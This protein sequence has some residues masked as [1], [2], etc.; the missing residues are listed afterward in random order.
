MLVAEAIQNRRSIRSYQTREVPEDT[1][2][3]IL[4]LTRYTP[5][6][7][8]GQPWRFVVIRDREIKN[9]L[10]EIKR[11]RCPEEKK[12]YAASYLKNAPVVVAICVER[13]RS[14]DRPIENGVLA[15]GYLMLAATARGL[16][17]VYLSAY[18]DEDPELAREVTSLLELP[19]DTFPV[20]LIPLGFAAE[21]PSPKNLRPLSEMV[22]NV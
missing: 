11:D 20:A 8:N 9:R 12:A 14:Y 16:G 18:R 22:A 4:D 1:I 5:S 2:E 6:A 19:D 10:G 15:A 17:T 3:E 13:S 21:E 7:M